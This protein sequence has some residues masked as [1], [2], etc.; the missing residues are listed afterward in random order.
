MKCSCRIIGWKLEY[1]VS[2]PT[3]HSYA[4]ESNGNGMDNETE[5]VMDIRVYEDRM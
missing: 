1:S 2:E 5:T 4:R 3:L